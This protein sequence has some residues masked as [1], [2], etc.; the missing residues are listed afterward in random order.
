MCYYIN[1]REKETKEKLEILSKANIC[2]MIGEASRRLRQ[3]L[4]K[5][6]I[7]VLRRWDFHYCLLSG[8]LHSF[9]L[10]SKPIY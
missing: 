7:L 3:I 9:S 1:T 5:T 2:K 4:E 6:N 8:R 10:T